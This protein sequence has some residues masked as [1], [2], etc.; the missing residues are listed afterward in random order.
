[1]SEELTLYIVD[2]SETG[3]G[4]PD[5]FDATIVSNR[6]RLK[7]YSDNTFK[8]GIFAELGLQIDGEDDIYYEQQMIAGPTNFEGTALNLVISPDGKH[9]AGPPDVTKEDWL[10]LGRGDEGTTMVAGTEDTY[11][12]NYLVS[13]RQGWT[14]KYHAHAQLLDSIYMLYPDPNDPKGTSFPRNPAADSLVGYRFHFKRL[15]QDERMKS[16]KKNKDNKPEPE[17]TVLCATDALG[18][19]EVKSGGKKSTS[20]IKTNA[21]VA[22][23]SSNNATATF[24][25]SD[26]AE[27]FDSRLENAILELLGETPQELT[28]LRSQVLNSFKSGADK[29]AAIKLINNAKWMSSS[30][31]PWTFDNGS[32]S[33]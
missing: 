7:R 5:D 23:T 16:K 31:R 25:T 9:L 8:H 15:A 28:T 26:D 14:P 17:Y 3:S 32:L 21:P 24:A 22:A 2:P 4:R 11:T 20:A 12:G 27:S 19:V 30:D 10:A 1:M 33:I 6:F 13:L 18:K 29:G